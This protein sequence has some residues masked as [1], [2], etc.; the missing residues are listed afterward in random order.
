M[1]DVEIWRFRKKNGKAQLAGAANNSRGFH[2][3]VWGSLEKKYGFP[4]TPPFAKR[5]PIWDLFGSERM[6]VDDQI[7]MGATF[8]HFVIKRENLP[9]LAASLAEFQAAHPHPTINQII[10]ALG[11]EAGN[12]DTEA[13]GFNIS[14]N[15]GF[16]EVGPNRRAY[17]IRTDG[18]HQ[19]LFEILREKGVQV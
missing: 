17:N 12:S 4:Q 5:M 1:S 9:R 13:I 2:L 19:E 6:S 7:V 14:V 18:R 10:A 3:H 15:V 8:D 16:W 11:C